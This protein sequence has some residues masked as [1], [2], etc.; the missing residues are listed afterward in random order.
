MAES[1][2]PETIS[3]TTGTG[4]RGDRAHS[5]V[6]RSNEPMQIGSDE[7]VN[8]TGS[9]GEGERHS[10]TSNVILPERGEL[11][12]DSVVAMRRWYHHLQHEFSRVVG[13]ATEVEFLSDEWWELISEAET[14]S[15]TAETILGFIRGA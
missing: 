14:I 12:G 6:L 10:R 2:Q 4:G 11:P 8:T 9:L 13:R 3:C 5:R 7:E 1:N 15:D